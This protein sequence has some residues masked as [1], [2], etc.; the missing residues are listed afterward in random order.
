MVQDSDRQWA[1]LLSPLIVEGHTVQ[2]A[3]EPTCGQSWKS[4]SNCVFGR[5]NIIFHEKAVGAA[6]LKGGDEDI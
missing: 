2:W 1:S 5:E 6:F 3:A 4:E